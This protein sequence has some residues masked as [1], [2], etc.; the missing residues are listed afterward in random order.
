MAGL[1]A[2]PRRR[3]GL[4]EGSKHTQGLGDVEYFA[5]LRNAPSSDELSRL[6]TKVAGG[7][8]YYNPA[9][10]SKAKYYRPSIGADPQKEFRA[11]EGQFP[12]LGTAYTG[13]GVSVPAVQAHE[14]R[15]AGAR[16][17]LGDFTRD[18]M[19]DKW[20]EEGGQVHD[21]LKYK[22]EGAVEVFDRPQDPAGS[23]GTMAATL[24]ANMKPE[25]TDVLKR[26]AGGIAADIMSGLGVPPRSKPLGGR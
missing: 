17:I 23:L 1:R 22:G 15:H 5:E 13:M 10:E 14:F 8:L 16:H 25:W 26:R 12:T 11:M 2:L 6:G 24:E 7:G 19:V 20:G 3:A 18:Q 4:F 21:I 9:W